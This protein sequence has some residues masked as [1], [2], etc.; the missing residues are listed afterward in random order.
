MPPTTTR[1]AARTQT[2][3]SGEPSRNGSPPRATSSAI[4][5]LLM[6]SFPR[7]ISFPKSFEFSSLRRRSG[8]EG[9]SLIAGPEYSEED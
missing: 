5:S 8:D 1:K 9:E 4:P 7:R 2:K 6:P 3:E